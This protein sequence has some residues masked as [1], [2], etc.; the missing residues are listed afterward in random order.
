MPEKRHSHWLEGLLIGGLAG[1]VV[2]MLF[3]PMSGKETRQKLGEKATDLAT[4]MKE[5]YNV[6]LEKSKCTYESLLK[7]LKKADAVADEKTKM[8]TEV[9]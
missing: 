5:E 7:Q 4:R 3:A 6:A 1:M 2:G 8:N 9:S